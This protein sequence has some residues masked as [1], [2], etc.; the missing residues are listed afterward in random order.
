MLIFPAIDIK[1][2]QC[3]RL[4]QGKFDTAEQVAADYMQTTL[5]FKKA[6]CEWIHMV[7]LDGSLAGRRVNQAIYLDVAQNSGLKVELGGGIRTMEDIDFYLS[8]GIS[9][10]ILGSVVLENPALVEQAIALYGPEKIAVG[11]DAKRGKVATRGWLD[12]NEITYLELAKRVEALGVEYIIFTDIGRDGMLAGPNLEQ[13]CA[14]QEAVGCKITASGGVTD[15]GDIISLRD[16]GFYGAICGR[17]IYKGTLDLAEAVR[18][19]GT[20]YG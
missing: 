16:K 8:N 19:A 1:G 15:I 17:S 18:E 13:L 3:V 20:Q 11:I 4:Y 2:G 5:S 14:L 9:R 12:V 6:G 7:D 10:V